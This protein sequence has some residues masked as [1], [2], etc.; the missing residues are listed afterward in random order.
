MNPRNSAAGTIRQLD[1]KLAAE[2]PLSTLVLRHRRHRGD[3]VREPLGGPDLAARA[4]LPGQR[5]RSSCSTARTTSSPSARPGRS[6]AAA[7]DFEIDGVVVKVN[8]VEL[9]RRL[10]VVG[11]EPRWAI[12]WKFPPTTKTTVLK[13]IE[14]NV[15]KFGD[16]HPFA[17]LEPVQRGRRHG[18]ARDAP[19][20]GG[21][22]AQG[23]APRRRGHRAARRRRHPAGALARAARRRAPRP[24]AARPSRP[25]AA[26]PATRRR[27]SRRTPSSPSAPTARTARASSWQLLKHFASRG[28]MDIDGSGRE[29]G[30]AA[31]G[32]RAGQARRRL[33]P[34]DRRAAHRARGLRRDLRRPPRRGDRRLQAAHRSAACCSRSASRRSATSP[35][36]T[37]PS[38]SARSTRCWP[39]RRSRSPRRQGIGPKMA[40]LHPRAARRRADARADRRPAR[41]GPAA[42]SR[43][44][45]PPG[46]GPLAGK[47]FVLT[48]TLPDADARAGDRADP[49]RRRPRDLV[50]VEEDRLPRRRRSAGLQAREGRA[51]GRRGHRRGRAARAACAASTVAA[52]LARAAR[53]PRRA[54]P[55]RPGRAPRRQRCS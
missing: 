44:A 25:S 43:R 28:A 53:A 50:G 41:A 16:L 8:D 18:Q 37:S 52:R 23:P 20:R 1:P 27:S 45:P 19:Q 24:R 22:R 30:R 49:R 17:V 3:H 55:A 40:E 5:R 48:G 4:P 46:E 36:A 38:T 35:G 31:H 32:G 39:P 26:R 2:R 12:A 6:A 51:A 14:W 7:L 29:A 21:H 47:T 9:Q 33:L 42:S 11:R 10:G 54:G 13:G 15:G 34:A